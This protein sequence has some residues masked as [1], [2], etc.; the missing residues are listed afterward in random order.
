MV[1][2]PGVIGGGDGD[3]V[4]EERGCTE[5]M[6]WMESDVV[7]DESDNDVGCADE[8]ICELRRIQTISC[9]G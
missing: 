2:L 5:R 8:R 9:Q 3:G 6:E 7:V 4:A 1:R